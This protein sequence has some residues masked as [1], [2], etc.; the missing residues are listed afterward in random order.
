MSQEIESVKPILT[1]IDDEGDL[2]FNSTGPRGKKMAQAILAMAD[3]ARKVVV[4][5][6]GEMR[7]MKR[8]SSAENQAKQVPDMVD[9]TPARRPAPSAS[10][11]Q[12]SLARPASLA[13]HPG[14]VRR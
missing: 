9:V 3:G 5:S 13:R 11:A 7:V 12:P 4:I 2:V 10:P 8:N 6:D 14:P 1:V